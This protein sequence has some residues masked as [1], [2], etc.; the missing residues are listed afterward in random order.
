MT[1]RSFHREAQAIATAGERRSRRMTWQ[2][3][4]AVGLAIASR[5]VARGLARPTPGDL[6]RIVP[7]RGTP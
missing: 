7:P 6:F 5:L 3:K 4:E 1:A 2:A